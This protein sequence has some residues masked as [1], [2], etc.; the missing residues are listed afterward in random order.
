M[1]I[2]DVRNILTLILKHSTLHSPLNMFIYIYI[3]IETE[4]TFFAV[5]DEE[6]LFWLVRENTLA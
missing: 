2:F 3:Y 4:T 6:F 5:A 1:Y